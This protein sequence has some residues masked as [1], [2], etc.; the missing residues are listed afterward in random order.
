M[1][2]F[3][4]V[5]VDRDVAVDCAV[6]GWSCGYSRALKL[7]CAGRRPVSAT[8]PARPRGCRAPA[9]GLSRP[10]C[11]QNLQPRPG[12]AV[13]RNSGSINSRC[14]ARLIPRPSDGKRPGWAA[15]AGPR[16]L[17]QNP[18][19]LS[20]ACQG[21]APGP[22]GAAHVP[23]PALGIDTWGGISTDSTPLAGGPSGLKRLI[24]RRP[25]ATD[26]ALRGPGRARA[27][28]SHELQRPAPARARRRAW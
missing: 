14:R 23:R 18:A 22:G 27:G 21:Q 26:F 8:V 12:V 3:G 16:G 7:S 1:R 17:G 13:K 5:Q 10:G 28:A 24:S 2:K 19:R 4:P 25:E 15:S 6:R 9:R 20:R 11:G